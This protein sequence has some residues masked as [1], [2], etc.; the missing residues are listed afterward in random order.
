MTSDYANPANSNSAASSNTD[1]SIGVEDEAN[2]P[3]KPSSYSHSSY[4]DKDKDKGV[5]SKS[6][7]KTGYFENIPSLEE[8]YGKFVGK[9]TV[10]K[11]MYTIAEGDVNDM[12][13]S[14]KQ[15]GSSPLEGSKASY[16]DISQVNQT[17]N[18]PFSFHAERRWGTA[19][20]VHD[21][22]YV[23]TA[24]T[25]HNR[26]VIQFYSYLDTEENKEDALDESDTMTCIKTGYS[27]ITMVCDIVTKKQVADEAGIGKVL[28]EVWYLT[29][30]VTP[31]D[32]NDPCSNIIGV[33]QASL[34]SSFP[35]SSPTLLNLDAGYDDDN[36][37]VCIY[38]DCG[39]FPM[40]HEQ[41]KTWQ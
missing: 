30:P 1:A 41:H 35:E 7:T 9:Y 40:H 11:N 32:E 2:Q 28:T 38:C 27:D 13:L 17:G 22:S 29:G 15:L 23:G 14:S 39:A 19:T 5:P 8:T 31:E 12:T 37:C 4:K 3:H 26:E 20:G 25:A 6:S 16:I 33:D 24:S 10:C 21:I 34:S 36:N 18:T